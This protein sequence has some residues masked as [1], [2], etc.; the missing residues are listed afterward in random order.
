MCMHAKIADYFPVI[1][2]MEVVALLLLN[3]AYGAEILGSRFSHFV[4]RL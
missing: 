1:K 2:R 3:V 4:R